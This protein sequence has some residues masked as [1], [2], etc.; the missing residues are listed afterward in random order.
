[1]DPVATIIAFY[2][3]LDARDYAALA[4]LM[5]PEGVWHRQGAA[6][7]GSEAIMLAMAKRSPTMRIHHLLT[8]AYAQPAGPGQM[9]VIA[10]MMVIRHE[11]GAPLDGPAPLKGFENIRTI[12]ADVSETPAGWRIA[13]MWADPV[14]F[15]A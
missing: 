10:Y 1:M 3:H 12:Y 15:A 2:R 13:K 8:N 5:L 9:R 7:S 14:S 11:P 6:L 4:A